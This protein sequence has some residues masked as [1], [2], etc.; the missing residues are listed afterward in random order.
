MRYPNNH[1]MTTLGEQLKRYVKNIFMY[2]TFSFNLNSKA[3]WNERFAQM[4][5]RWRDKD[6]Y[7]I[8]EYLPR[9]AS[10]TLLDVG[11]ALGDGCQL[12]KAQFPN[13]NI[14]GIDI[15]DF[16]IAK[17]RSKGSDIE[18]QVLDIRDSPLPKYY[19]FITIIETLEHFDEPFTI[20]DKCLNKTK[21]ALIIQTPFTPN[22]SGRFLAVS[23]HRFFFNEQTF[24]RYPTCKV[25]F[26]DSGHIVY[27]F[28]PKNL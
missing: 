24:S 28:I 4:G 14:T 5:Q 3:Y 15:S 11:C 27:K 1:I 25:F 20:V 6:Y 22:R 18:Y 2:R 19:D 9:N 21:K 12:I 10:F 8:L 17:A 13:A 26:P 23:E 16:A 7:A